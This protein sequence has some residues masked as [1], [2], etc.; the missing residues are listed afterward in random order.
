MLPVADGEFENY[1]A[2]DRILRFSD[3]LAPRIQKS[4]YT[5]A[6]ESGDILP[7]RATV[8]VEK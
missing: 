1:V 5:A 3:A 6:F 2:V 8:D 4:S 7:H